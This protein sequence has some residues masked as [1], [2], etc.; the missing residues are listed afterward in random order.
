MLFL[1]MFVIKRGRRQHLHHSSYYSEGTRKRTVD[2]N[3]Q[4]RSVE[5]QLII[6]YAVF[7]VQEII[8]VTGL[9]YKN[10]MGERKFLVLFLLSQN[11]FFY[12][13]VMMRD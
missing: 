2:D 12:V 13:C 9:K 6:S 10:S 7:T 4:A 3:I 1:A 8:I 5:L 11:E